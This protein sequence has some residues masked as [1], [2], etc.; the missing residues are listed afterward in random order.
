[1]CNI[2]SFYDWC[3]ENNKQRYLDLWDY[4]LND[5]KPEEVSRATKEKYYFICEKHIHESF[6]KGIWNLVNS[7]DLICPECNSFYTWCIEN[8][9][10]DI[11]DAWN[12][13]KN[14]SIH[15]FSQSSGKKCYFTL[16]SKYD[17]V[18]VR[19]GDITGY[20][21]LDPIKKYYNSFGYYLLEKYG[22]DGILKYWSK[23]NN[24]EPFLF[25]RG[26][27]KNIY[28]ICQKKDYH[29]SY[30]TTPDLFTRGCRCSYCASKIIHP[31]DSFAQYHINNTDVNFIDK[32]WH[33][34]NIVDPFK[35]SVYDNNTP[36]KI[37]CQEKDYH[38]YDTTPANF[39]A[40]NRCP[41]CRA[42]GVKV[43]IK[44]SLGSLYPDIIP[45]WSDKNKKS[46]FEYRTSS[47]EQVWLK[48][49]DGIHDDYLRRI[50]DYT[51]KNSRLCPSC[52]KERLESFPQ[53]KVRL[54]LESLGYDILH[55]FNCSI[56][57]IN[58]RTKCKMPF[59]NEIVELK[60]ICEV[61]GLQHYQLGGWHV[62]QAKAKGTTPE[63]EFEYQQWK[64]QYKKQYALERG[65]H[66]LEIPYY[67]TQD[68]TYINLINEKIKLIS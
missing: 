58:Y 48:C 50:A 20:K 35:I 56:I 46:P 54:Y 8:N 68:D 34:G 27:G 4:E 66:Y 51:Y 18:H 24:C 3:I 63:E 13:S 49:E 33:K 59:D 7:K 22:E 62:T 11:I 44:D 29:S 43:H 19:I 67:T 36:I 15:S 61:H 32:Y 37:Q 60:L 65:Y 6:L 17:G 52:V 42:L 14:G 53:E 9:R 45:I 31:L 57:P 47:H 5:K 30:R 1:M 26:S 64:D 21:Q 10:Q 40:G 38:A 41:Y 12:T 25:D 2:K 16:N 28:M 55:E 23:E 39:S